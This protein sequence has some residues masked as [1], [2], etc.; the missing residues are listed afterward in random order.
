MGKP[1]K[2]R[3]YIA[4]LP[5]ALREE[6]NQRMNNGW[7]YNTIARWLF[8]QTADQDI[9]DLELKTGDPYSLVWT[10][11]TNR[12]G[13]HQE[14]CEITLCKWY[15]GPHQQWLILQAS[16]D[17]LMRVV[18]R[19]ER[20]GSVASEKAQPNSVTGGNLCI[21]SLLFEALDQIRAGSQDPEVMARLANAWARL[22]QAGTESEKLKLQMQEATDAGL[23][24][25]YEDV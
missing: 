10:R 21:R 14:A 18:E 13:I 4:R 6:I 12:K 8:E 20:I 2:P 3:G 7:Q 25:L 9:P 19:F 5:A 15:R 17:P 11:N 1:L 23:Q 24:A 16:R 22:N